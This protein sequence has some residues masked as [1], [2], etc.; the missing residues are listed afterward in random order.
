M[1]Y[2]GCKMDQNESCTQWNEVANLWAND[3]LCTNCG[4]NYI[5]LYHSAFEA[6][7]HH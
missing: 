5:L 3:D 2:V 4:S 7:I 6:D 1:T